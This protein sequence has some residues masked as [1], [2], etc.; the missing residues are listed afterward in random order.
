MSGRV[1]MHAHAR[2]CVW[3]GGVLFQIHKTMRVRFTFPHR[4]AGP[5][6]RAHVTGTTIRSGRFRFGL[7]SRSC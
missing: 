7:C 6:H 4:L 2:V 1:T 5:A 3:G